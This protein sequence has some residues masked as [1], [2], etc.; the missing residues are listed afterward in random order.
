[1]RVRLAGCHVPADRRQRTA[2]G[3]VPWALASFDH[4]WPNLRT[5]MGLF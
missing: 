5:E 4:Y 3:M 1:M 2:A